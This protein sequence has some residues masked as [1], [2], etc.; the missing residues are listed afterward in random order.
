MKKDEF[1]YARAHGMR[2]I[3]IMNNNDKIMTKPSPH[4]THGVRA[5]GYYGHQCVARESILA[6]QLSLTK[7]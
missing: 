5:A 1:M 2:I 7:V 6:K 3:I 4:D